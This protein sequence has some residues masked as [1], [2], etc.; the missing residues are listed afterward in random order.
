MQMEKG[1]YD[2]ISMCPDILHPEKL[3]AV[4]NGFLTNGFFHKSQKNLSNTWPLVSFCHPSRDTYS[5][6]D[7]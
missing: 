3:A 4:T 1:I 6:F 7:T 2:C 5:V